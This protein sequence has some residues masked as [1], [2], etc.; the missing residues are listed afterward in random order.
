MR[1][2]VTRGQR[3]LHNEANVKVNLFLCLTQHHAMKTYRGVEVWLHTFLT[4]APDGGEWSASRPGLCTPGE[5]P[6]VPIGPQ[7]RFIICTLHQILE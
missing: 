7:S 5:K 4:S 2:K 1:V 3:R 6:P